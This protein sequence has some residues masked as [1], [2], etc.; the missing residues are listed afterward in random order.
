MTGF[1]GA[2]L[3]RKEVSMAAGTMAGVGPSSENPLEMAIQQFNRAADHLHLDHGIRD[4]L[5]HPKRELTV[6]FPV[7]M[8]T[9]P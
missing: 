1:S 4:L 7:R 9:V 3:E 2:R 6:H 5:C 8:E